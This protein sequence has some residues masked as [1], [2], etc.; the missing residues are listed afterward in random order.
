MLFL[1][2]RFIRPTT[3]L[4]GLALGGA[5][6]V[7]TRSVHAESGSPAKVFGRGLSMV[8]LP[9]ESSEKVNH[10]TKLLRFK[11]PNDSDI[12]GL[13]LTCKQHLEGP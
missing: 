9:L 10:N 11:L 2:T 13:S 3:V 4:S 8:S 6:Y 7:T 12:S 1:P 5:S